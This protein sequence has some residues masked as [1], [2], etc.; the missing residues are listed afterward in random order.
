MRSPPR[1]SS[2]ST[3]LADLC[4]VALENSLLHRELDREV[5]ELRRGIAGKYRFENLLAAVMRW[6]GCSV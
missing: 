4:A 6:C 2:S 5:R 1:I 3:A